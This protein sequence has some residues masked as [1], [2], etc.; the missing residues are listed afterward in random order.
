MRS[1]SSTASAST[2]GAPRTSSSL[3]MT[4]PM[5]PQA[6]HTNVLDDRMHS[7]TGPNQGGNIDTTLSP[8]HP[9][10]MPVVNS[11][12]MTYRPLIVQ[13]QQQ[14][15]QQQQQHQQ[16]IPP[17]PML[18]SLGPLFPAPAQSFPGLLFP[19]IIPLLPISADASALAT[20]ANPLAASFG[21]KRGQGYSCHHCK[22]TKPVPELFLC[23][24][25]TQ[26]SLGS[27]KCR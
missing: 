21:F 9:Q 2:A 4:Q 23:T 13:Q 17:Q 6:N 18:L 14:Q 22:T 25:R 11:A 20:P 24:A 3:A 27:K 15:A 5:Q 12:P 19:S 1:A 26:T 7:F 16:A 8:S 10:I